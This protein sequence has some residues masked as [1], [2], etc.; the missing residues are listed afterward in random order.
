M[1]SKLG[2]RIIS[3]IVI[4]TIISCNYLNKDNETEVLDNSSK[5][6]AIS[7]NLINIYPHDTSSYTQG[8]IWHK[9]FLYESTG[10]YNKS[11]LRK[12]DIKTGKNIQEIRLSDP[13]FFGEGIT[14]FDNKIYQLTWQNNRVFVYDL[15]TMQKIN[16]LKWPYE[17][18]GITHNKTNLII[19]TG[20]SN[21]YFVSPSDFKIIKTVCVTDNYGPVS[22]LNEIEYINGYV[23]A[24]KYLTDDILKI[25]PETGVVEGLLNTQGILEKS[26][27][28]L[29]F[30]KYSTSSGNV[31]NGIAYDSTKN[32]L[33]IT[34][35]LW[36]FLFE[37][38]LN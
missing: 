17:G 21:L 7:Y 14:I 30:Q 8:L 5:P 22:N 2:I 34:G 10:E 20:S 35:K 9:G 18:W 12:V 28:Q 15:N 27:I 16:E 29:D 6:A 32:C 3:V 24:N 38:K 36:P 33:Y 11:R 13:S 25:N 26:G 1:I 31:L 23:Y 37:I 4:F 19:S